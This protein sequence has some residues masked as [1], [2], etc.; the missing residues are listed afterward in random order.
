MNSIPRFYLPS[1]DWNEGFLL[2]TG[3]EAHHCVRVLRM[4]VGAR[5]QVFDGV[6]RR[7]TG[8]ITHT[9]K[10]QVE[11]L[12]EEEEVSAPPTTYLSLYQAVPKGGN[13]ELIVQ[14]SV[15]LG[16]MTI[17]PL[18]TQNTVVKL[19]QLEKK[20]EKWRKVA[21]EACKQCGQD[22][23][24]RVRVPLPFHEWIGQY[25]VDG[26]SIVAALDPRAID[27]SEAIS[28]FQKTGSAALLIGPEGDFTQEEY[29]QAI[30]KGFE[31]VNLGKIVLRV[32]TATLYAISVLKFA[33]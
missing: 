28:Q 13:M 21:L 5:I 4:K 20:T 8:S 10:E 1:V 23:L 24:P 29:D 19:D 32:E 26:C 3:E 14:K 7:A 30:E 33:L 17:Q 11:I 22:W 27:F 15:E 18:L 9:R 6:G 12:V 16:V 2:L 25:H 31:P